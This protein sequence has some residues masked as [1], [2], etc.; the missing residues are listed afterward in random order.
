[1]RLDA[2]KYS[3]PPPDLVHGLV[4]DGLLWLLAH[5]SGLSPCC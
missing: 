1:M 4:A 3:L 2:V 5:G